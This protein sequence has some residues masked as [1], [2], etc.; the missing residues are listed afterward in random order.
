MAPNV[1]I[2]PFVTI[3]HFDTPQALEDKYGGFLN[4]SIVDDF[5]DY[6]ELL[7]QTYGDR[8]KNWITINEPFVL[9]LG[10]DLGK[11]APGRCSLPPPFGPCLAGNSSTEPYIVG[12]NLILAHATAAKLY[13]V[14]FQAKQGGE[15]GI[16]LVG[17]FVEPLNPD[18]S[19]D[20]A[21]TKRC[22]DFPIGW[23]A[24]KDGVPIGPKACDYSYNILA[25]RSEYVYSYRNG[26]QKLLEFINEK[27][28]VKVK[29]YFYRSL[30][31]NSEWESGY[32]TRLGLHFI[33]YKDNCK[34]IPK[35]SAKWFHGFLKARGD[36]TTQDSTLRKTSSCPPDQLPITN[37][38][39]STLSSPLAAC[40]HLWLFYLILSWLL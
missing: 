3:L 10:Y 22:L 15:I 7:F 16:A 13:K 24:M 1:G 39:S 37:S 36:N 34:R 21:A 33:D 38:S 35:R 19:D 5:K 28:G 8:V 25:E 6:C 9:V 20:E 26:L 17:E 2:T 32:G 14:K 30:F 18:S 40:G 31:D 23:C 4:R 29:G 11:C 27:N 12:H